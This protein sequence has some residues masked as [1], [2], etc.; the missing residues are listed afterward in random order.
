[1][2]EKKGQSVV[3]IPTE[4]Y[5]RVVGYFRPVQNWNLGKRQEFS[6][7]AYYNVEKVVPESAAEQK[8][9]SNVA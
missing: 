7:R 1:M 8:T 5:S 6:E 2:P 3:R 9:E 4:I